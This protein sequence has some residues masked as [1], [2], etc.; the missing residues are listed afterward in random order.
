MTIREPKLSSSNHCL[1]NMKTT[2]FA[3]ALAA[4]VTLGDSIPTSGPVYTLHEKRSSL[5]RLWARGDRVNSDAIVPIRIG[6]TQSNLENGY[7]HLME[8]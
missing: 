1:L 6:L 5:P 2:L 4:F 8:V 7:A 3:V